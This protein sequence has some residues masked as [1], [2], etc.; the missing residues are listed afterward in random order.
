MMR[1]V[2]VTKSFYRDFEQIGTSW[3]IPLA[4]MVPQA[5]GALLQIQHVLGQMPPC[6]TIV[7]IGKKTSTVTWFS[8]GIAQN[9]QEIFSAGNDIDNS[10][11]AAFC[12]SMPL[13]EE[14][15]LL[16][17]NLTL[18]DEIQEKHIHVKTDTGYQK[19]NSLTF[20]Q[21]L[22]SAYRL[23]LTTIAAQLPEHPY[24]SHI[25]FTGG[26]V[27]IEGFD[28][29]LKEIFIPVMNIEPFVVKNIFTSLDGS[30]RHLTLKDQSHHAVSAPLFRFKE[31][32]KE[33]FAS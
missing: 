7:D 30:V 10:I 12:L 15:K 31:L 18:T 3:G 27:L 28:S 9:S 11:A 5:T 13:A 19:I 29:F 26:S 24:R 32:L 20:V 2:F 16:Y 4:G 14:V 17:G 22:R 21:A 8:D 23:L 6:L 33:Y 1:M 25:F